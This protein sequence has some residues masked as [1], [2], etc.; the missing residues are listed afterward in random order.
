MTSQLL[1]S[2]SEFTSSSIACICIH[3]YI[4]V[5]I[6]NTILFWEQCYT[7]DEKI[8]MTDCAAYAAN[9]SSEKPLVSKE[10]TAEAD[11][12]YET[13]DAVL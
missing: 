10:S 9:P 5:H 11:R 1:Q 7:S 12:D 6:Y 2:P 3:V 4:A 13:P 8:P